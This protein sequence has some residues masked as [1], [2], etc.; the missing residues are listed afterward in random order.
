MKL[1]IDRTSREQQAVMQMYTCRLGKHLFQS[2]QRLV[3]ARIEEVCLQ[4]GDNVY[5]DARQWLEHF[6]TTHD[7][8]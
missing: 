2:A 5:I 8:R 3:V 1:L 7:D 6:V 4:S